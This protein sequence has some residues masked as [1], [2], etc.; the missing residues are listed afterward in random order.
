MKMVVFMKVIG[1]KIKNDMDLEHL[2]GQ[3]DLLM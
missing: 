1:I 2:N 3:M